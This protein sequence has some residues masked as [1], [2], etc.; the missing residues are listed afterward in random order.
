MAR[1]DTNPPTTILSAKEAK[2]GFG[3]MLDAAQRGPVSITKNGRKVAVVLSQEEYD[4]FE[5]LED[6]YWGERAALAHSEKSLG[7]KKS[8]QLL[9]ELLHAE[10]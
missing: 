3:K 9:T 1:M 6:A 4:K 5:A 8:E 10:D 2:D 7:T